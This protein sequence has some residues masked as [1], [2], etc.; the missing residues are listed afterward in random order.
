VGI[1]R[2]RKIEL[3]QSRVKLRPGDTVVL[4]TSQE[5]SDSDAKRVAAVAQRALPG[6]V[7]IAL[8]DKGMR[9]RTVLHPDQHSKLWPIPDAPR[10]WDLND[11]TT[12]SK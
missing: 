4:Q 2:R 6:A 10:V 7:G 8:F 5:L 3:Y 11:M 9:L 12:G 1:F